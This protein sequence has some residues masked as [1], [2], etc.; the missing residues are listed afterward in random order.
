[1]E[2]L[3][4]IPQSSA[5]TPLAEHQ[6]QTPA[7]FYSGPAVLYY[8]S[9]DCKILIQSHDLGSASPLSNLSVGNA[10]AT[11][12]HSTNGGSGD[13]GEEDHEVSISGV[14]VWVTSQ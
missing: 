6:S 9:A 14:E 10:P 8:H 2:I 7:S 11:N 12:G 4:D 3:R 1:M 13:T 5:F